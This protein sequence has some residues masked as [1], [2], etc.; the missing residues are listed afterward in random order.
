MIPFIAYSNRLQGVLKAMSRA[1]DSECAV[2][3]Y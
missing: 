2:A 1:G 3:L